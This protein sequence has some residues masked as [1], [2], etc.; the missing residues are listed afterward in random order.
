MSRRILV[1][2][3]LAALAPATFDEFRKIEREVPSA[4]DPNM[5]KILPR[6]MVEIARAP[7]GYVPANPRFG[8]SRPNVS[9]SAR[10]ACGCGEMVSGSR[11]YKLGHG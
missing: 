5:A 4:I 6:E 8:R 1:D 7:R 10:C 3:A 9:G 2:A 11:K